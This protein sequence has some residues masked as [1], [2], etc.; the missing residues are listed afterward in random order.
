MKGEANEDIP[1]TIARSSK[2]DKEQPLTPTG[3]STVG[4]VGA[5][6]EFHV[7]VEIL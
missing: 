4:S 5:E 6:N 7:L 1:C 2:A 3:H